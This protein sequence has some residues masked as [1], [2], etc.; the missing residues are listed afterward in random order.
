MCITTT[1]YSTGFGLQ[2]NMIIKYIEIS[3]EKHKLNITKRYLTED[4]KPKSQDL[5]HYIKI[6]KL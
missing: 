6:H 1:L 2:L 3:K 5:E 4:P